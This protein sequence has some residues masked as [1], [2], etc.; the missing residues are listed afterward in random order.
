M[1]KVVLITGASRGIGKACALLLAEQGFDIA[2]NYHQQKEQAQQLCNTI[3]AM[4][5]KA[6]IFQADVS[7]ELEVDTLFANIKT[8][9]GPVS[10]LVNNV[11][12]L[13]PQMPVT[14]MSA[15][16]INHIL[17]VNVTSAFLCAKA[18]IAHMQH[19]P[20]Q[21]CAIVN[22]SSAA[23]RLGAPHEYV[24]YAASKG[25]MDSFT[26]GLS[27]ELA[28]QGIR[29][30]AVRPGFIATDIHQDGGEPE[31]LKRVAPMIPLGR[32]GQPYEV[33]S[34]VAWLLSNHASY[35]T[36]AFIDLAGGK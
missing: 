19:H 23:S 2:I 18:A 22:I 3:E 29:V 33:A 12:I 35:V 27:L 15:A 20:T 5:R 13:L 1:N 4:G 31:R 17:S 28:S 14:Q 10:H 11:G 7:Q 36:G 34:A 32:A 24:D 6:E 30:N 16:R 9:L 26:T 21:S 8:T 25:A